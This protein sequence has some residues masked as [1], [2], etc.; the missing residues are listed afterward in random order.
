MKSNDTKIKEI[1]NDMTPKG[2]ERVAT[3]EEYFLKFDEAA[4]GKLLKINNNSKTQTQDFLDLYDFLMN[5]MY[6][7][8]R[9]E[10]IEKD[11]ITDRIKTHTNIIKLLDIIKK[12]SDRY[13]LGKIYEE[14]LDYYIPLFSQVIKSKDIDIAEH[15]RI[16]PKA[17]NYKLDRPIARKAYERDLKKWNKTDEEIKRFLLHRENFKTILLILAALGLT[18]EEIKVAYVG[19]VKRKLRHGIQRNRAIPKLHD[20][21]VYQ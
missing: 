10:S 17:A 1:M 6:T 15:N 4:L 21:F 19:E 16:K 8:S 7:R 9:L 14:L 18:Y 20:I 5:T 2:L 12:D 3:L 13:I 11:I